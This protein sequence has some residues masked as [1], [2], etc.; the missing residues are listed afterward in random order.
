MFS[1]M[2]NTPYILYMK[3]DK[4]NFDVQ[5]LDPIKIANKH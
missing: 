3:V 5:C 1:L 2:E 4:R